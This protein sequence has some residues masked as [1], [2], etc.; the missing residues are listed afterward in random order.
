MAHTCPNCGKSLIVP[1]YAI[2]NVESYQEPKKVVTGCCNK[3]V[4]LVPYT[5]YKPV[6]YEGDSEQDDWGNEVK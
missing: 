2:V 5:G 3:I 4:R 6:K 1:I